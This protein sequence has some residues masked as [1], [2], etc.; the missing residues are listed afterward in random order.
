MK[1]LSRSRVGRRLGHW[2]G[3]TIWRS[4]YAPRRAV[5]VF[6]YSIVKSGAVR[7]VADRPD[8][9][10]FHRC[11]PAQGNEVTCGSYRAPGCAIPVSG[12]RIPD[13]PDIVARND[14]DVLAD[15]EWALICRDA[16]N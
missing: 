14:G 8:I 5:P 6:G 2:V 7:S 12:R 10:G 13:L 1:P 16:R 4:N 15:G 9:I 11:Y 3:G